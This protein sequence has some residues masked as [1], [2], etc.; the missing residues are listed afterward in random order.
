[1]EKRVFIGIFVSPELK[2]KILGFKNKYRDLPV[3]WMIEEK[4]HLTLIP[5]MQLNDN[6]I[7]EMIKKLQT[8]KGKMGQIEIKF[9]HVSLG[10]NPR[11]PRLIWLE[12]EPNQKLIEL[13]NEITQILGLRA[14]GRPFRP[15]L[16]IARFKLRDYFDFSTKNLS[17]KIGW[18]FAAE[19]IY[20]IESK[21]LPDGAEYTILD[22][23]TL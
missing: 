21:R 6:E 8:L 20:I 4:L 5:P 12:G 1:M 17:E 22:K 3:R 19:S 2:R 14:E 11:R 15:H 13:K 9:S 23:I 7:V 10:P 18:F 16:T